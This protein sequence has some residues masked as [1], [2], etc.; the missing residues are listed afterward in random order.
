MALGGLH[1]LSMPFHRL[2]MG[3]GEIWG[4]PLVRKAQLADRSCGDFRRR[5]RVALG[6]PRVD[7]HGRRRIAS[8]LTGQ[9]LA[10]NGGHNRR[11]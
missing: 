3:L 7:H 9:V 6:S 2:L 4:G 1:F 8:Q 5:K 10:W 11:N